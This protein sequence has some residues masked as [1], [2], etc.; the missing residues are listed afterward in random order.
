MITIDLLVNPAVMLIRGNPEIVTALGTT[1]S[2]LM[3]HN[4][5]HLVEYL[6]RKHSTAEVYFQPEVPKG[7]RPGLLVIPQ[8]IKGHI[9]V[10]DDRVWP[11]S[12][13]AVRFYDSRPV[14]QVEREVYQIVHWLNRPPQN[15]LPS[16]T[17]NSS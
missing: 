17:I 8:G 4:H 14:G 12:Y 10:L 2:Q 13:V 6:N 5:L 1:K 11:G 7:K 9:L 3:A 16:R 15:P